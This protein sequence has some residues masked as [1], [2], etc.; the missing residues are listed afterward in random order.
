MKNEDKAVIRK[1]ISIRLMVLIAIE[2]VIAVALVGWASVHSAKNALQ[3]RILNGLDALATAREH[4]I[5]SLVEQDFERVALVASRTRLRECLAAIEEGDPDSQNLVE[6][7]NQ[8]LD[9]AQNSV[10][11]LQEVSAINLDGKIVSSTNRD[12]IDRKVADSELYRSSRESFYLGSLVVRREKLVYEI[13]APMKHPVNGTFIGVIAVKIEL[14]RLEE[15]LTDHT[16]LGETGELILGKREGDN[17]VLVG[18]L[19]HVTMDAAGSAIPLDS[20]EFKPLLLAMAH[21]EGITI[22]E[23]YR[24]E[25]VLAAYRYI[26][27]GDWG[28]VAKIDVSEAFKPVIV[29]QRRILFLGTLLAILGILSSFMVFKMISRPIRSLRKGVEKISGGQLDYRIEEIGQNEFGELGKAFNKMAARLEEDISERVKAE[30][31]LQES[32]EKFSKAFQFT[33]NLM[34]ITTMDDGRI[35]E[36]NDAFCQKL[37]YEREVCIGRTTTELNVW[38]NP[39]QRD[40]IVEK[41]KAEGFVNNIE[42]S[43]LLKSGE[44]KRL[45]ASMS[46]ITLKDQNYFLSVAMDISELVQAEEAARRAD[47]KRSELEFI[48][49]QSPMVVF[50]WRATEGWPVE[51]VSE[52]IRQFGYTPDD[53]YSGCVPYASIVYPDDLQ[54]VSAEVVAYSSEQDRDQFE[55]EYRIVS[56]DGRVMWI[57]DRTWIRRNEKGEITHFQGIIF[58]ITKRKR[59][60]ET[61]LEHEAFIHNILDSVNEGFAVIDREYMIHSAN[62]ALCNMVNLIEDKVVGRPCYEVLHSID[63]PCHQ[64]G[65]DCVV[66]LTYETGVSQL[67]IHEHESPTGE[68]RTIE[69]KSYPIFDSSGKVVSV[70][71]TMNDVTEKK[72]LE[73]QLFQA[74]KM[75]AVGRLAGGVAHDFNNMLGVIV[76]HVGLALGHMEQ[77]H[78]LYDHL[79]E[80]SKAAD[81]SAD[82]TR[83]LLAFARKQPADPKVLDLNETVEG[84]LKMLRPLLGEGIDLNWLPGDEVWPVKIDPTQVDQILVNLCVNARDAISD[85]GTITIETHSVSLDKADCADNLDMIPGDYVQLEVSDNGIGMDKQVL[86]KLFEPFFTTKERGKGTGLGLATVYGIVKQNNGFINV[87]S[88]LGQGSTF[89]IYLPR[90]ITGTDERQKESVTAP[91]VGGNETVLLVEDE[92]ALLDISKL[93]LTDYGYNVLSASSP[94]KAIQIG[95]E[96]VGDIHL[97]ITDVVLPEMNGKQLAKTLISI[98]PGIKCLFM[99]GY[100]D[101]IIADHGVLEGGVNFIQKPF[102]IDGLASKV[103]EVLDEVDSKE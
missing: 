39:Y 13:A 78:P 98:R 18:P 34:T 23:D 90:H 68:K 51:Y 61:V 52:N 92:P 16:G 17:V 93:I 76:I 10:D 21:E 89:N 29:L 5:T 38:A 47:K 103:R 74:Q 15:I 8:I 22:A 1:S 64:A 59:A 37:G 86:D 57:D 63:Y 42:T 96:Y 12:L 46:V 6:T 70:I 43:M 32:E 19:R 14:N 40:Q 35:I 26:D 58:E 7:M 88:E 31:S 33:P 81:R 4:E 73:E 102:S 65:E 79:K 11:M 82:L 101:D 54:R 99:S 91:A 87:Y 55:Q 30:E 28:L 84:L 3:D 48:V 53:F 45:V 95:K 60:E 75:D 2:I 56:P 69:I 25:K 85:V 72:R 41:V 24:H 36:I 50:L 77:H 66:K 27:L 20:G 49:D 97:L 94:G 100:T 44:I 83:Q 71:E 62:R 9:D 67:A 80:I